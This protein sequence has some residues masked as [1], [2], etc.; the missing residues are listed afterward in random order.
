MLP[1]TNARL[2]SITTEGSS[3]DWDQ[4]AGPASAAKW[5]GNEDA[6]V[7]I[8]INT[9]YS[10]TAGALAQQRDVRIIISGNLTDTDGNPLEIDAGDIFTYQW[11]GVTHSR[12]VMEWSAPYDPNLLLNDFVTVHLNPEALETALESE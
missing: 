10:T 3:E 6:Y 12:K 1:Q 7:M 11:R 8:K 2:I 9:R 5:T 4:P